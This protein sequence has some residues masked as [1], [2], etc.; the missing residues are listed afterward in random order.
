MS[1]YSTPE[2]KDPQLWQMA[3][4]RAA[5]KSHLLTYLLVNAGLWILWYLTSARTYGGSIP[6]PAWSTF[7]WG[8]GLVSHYIGAYHTNSV[9]TV[10]KEYNKLKQNQSN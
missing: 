9:N 6:W 8:I 3:R 2:D 7:G 1:Y 10:E 4:K 5:F